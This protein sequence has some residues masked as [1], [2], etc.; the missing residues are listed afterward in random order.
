MFEDM[1]AQNKLLQEK[2]SK[3]LVALESKE[4]SLE[5]AVLLAKKELITKSEVI[6]VF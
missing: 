3:K 6:L 2:L 5:Q 4:E 1:I